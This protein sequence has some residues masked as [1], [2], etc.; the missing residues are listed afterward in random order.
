MIINSLI[1]RNAADN[2]DPPTQALCIIND[3]IQLLKI[4][5]SEGFSM[6]DSAVSLCGRVVNV[7]IW[8][9]SHWNRIK[10]GHFVKIGSFVRFRNIIE[11]FLNFEASNIRCLMFHSKSALTP[12]PDWTYEI[13]ALLKT[14]HNRVIRKDLYNPESGILPFFWQTNDK[15]H[16]NNADS[17]AERTEI[18]NVPSLIDTLI[19]P[20]LGNLKVKFTIDSMIP[21]IDVTSLQLNGLKSFCFEGVDSKGIHQFQFAMH[22]YDNTAEMNAIITNA[23]AED[24]FKITAT[25]VCSD[26]VRKIFSQKHKD[27]IKKWSNILQNHTLLSGNIRSVVVDAVKLYLLDSVA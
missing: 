11:G 24:M 12:I 27:A 19:A 23:A 16:L 9:D 25:E 15:L 14:H 10:D 1:D 7:V 8:E 20:A 21:T 3:T 26:F 6:L 13:G 5:D 18:T 4:L 17:Y 2:S 22:I